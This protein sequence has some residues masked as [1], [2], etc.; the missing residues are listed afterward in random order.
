MYRAR[1]FSATELRP[2]TTDILTYHDTLRHFPAVDGV[3]EGVALQSY[4]HDCAIVIIEAGRRHTFRLFFKNHVFLP[5]NSSI[6]TGFW[7]GDI[8]VMRCA[9]RA[10]QQYVHV[11]SNDAALIDY[12][13]HR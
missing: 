8:V 12:A 2:Y 1:V 5:R 10:S 6:R 4:I 11:R 9:T 7:R 3:F 13:V